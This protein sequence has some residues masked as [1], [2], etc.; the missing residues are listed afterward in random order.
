MRHIA[1]VP[2][3]DKSERVDS[4]NFRSFIGEKSL[5]DLKIEQILKSKR[6]DEVIISSDS[7]QAELVAKKFS[8]SFHKRDVLFCNNTTS[9][10]DVIFN[11]VEQCSSFGDI[12]SWCHT[13][14][15]L[16]ENF[17]SAL[18]SYERSL[19]SG[20][21]GLVAVSSF[22]EFLVT[23][24]GRP[25]NYNWG[26]WHEYSQQLEKL[27]RVTGALFIA[28]REEILRNRYVVSRNPYLFETSAYEGIDIDTDYDFKLARLVY[29]NKGLFHGEM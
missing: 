1:I 17:S 29:Q 10:S 7:T 14:S 6:Y 5:L 28:E 23:K 8:V 22:S 18:E 3:K 25:Y 11:V 12:V 4:K 20:F 16:F 13:T 19:K 24:G 9:W 15:P 27:Y 2:V 21:N 26:V